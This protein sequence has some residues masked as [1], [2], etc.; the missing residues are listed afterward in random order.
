MKTQFYLI[1]SESGKV[2][3]T[4]SKP[5]LKWDEIVIHQRLDLPDKLF[6]KPQLNAEI[7]VTDKMVEPKVITPDM[8]DNIKQAIESAAGVEVRLTFPEVDA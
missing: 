4:K 3:T 8:Q 2:R 7:T 6:Q 1:V 5:D